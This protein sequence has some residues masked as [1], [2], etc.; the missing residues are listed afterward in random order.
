MSQIIIIF[1]SDVLLIAEAQL[2]SKLFRWLSDVQVLTGNFCD[3]LINSAVS[4]RNDGHLWYVTNALW[5]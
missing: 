2:N 4:N 1:L 3:P 5:F